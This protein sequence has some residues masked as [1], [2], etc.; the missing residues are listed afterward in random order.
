MPTINQLVR[1]NRSDKKRKSK[2][3]VLGIGLNSIQKKQT[4]KNS[5]QKSGVCT[6]VG[7]MTP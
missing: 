7:T 3:P 2:S 5:P 6:R 4:D 1:K